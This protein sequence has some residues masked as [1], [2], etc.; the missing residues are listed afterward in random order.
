M[1][2]LCIVYATI[3]NCFAVPGIAIGQVFLYLQRLRGKWPCCLRLL[4]LVVL[5][6]VISFGLL[7]FCIGFREQ[8]Y[9]V[10][11]WSFLPCSL[12]GAGP[13][14][15]LSP[16]LYLYTRNRVKQR[17]VK[18]LDLLEAE[19]IVDPDDRCQGQP[20]ACTYQQAKRPLYLASHKPDIPRHLI[21]VLPQPQNVKVSEA[22]RG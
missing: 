19:G 18:F 8:L 7:L 22:K 2:D 9:Y 21:Q 6:V 15:D 4:L 13:Q 17:V 11:K 3:T 14:F 10:L 5:G 16:Q 20:R 1:H 12:C